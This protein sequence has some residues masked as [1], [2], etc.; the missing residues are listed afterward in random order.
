MA[1]QADVEDKEY[2]QHSG[3]SRLA[4]TGA[5]VEGS[6]D[7]QYRF[8]VV[9]AHCPGEEGTLVHSNGLEREVDEERREAQENELVER[10]ETADTAPRE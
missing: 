2:A 3:P 7:R 9:E 10:K 5:E 1:A 4:W 6:A 8:A